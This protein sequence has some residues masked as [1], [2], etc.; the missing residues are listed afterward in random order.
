MGGVYTLFYL[1]ALKIPENVCQKP[2]FLSL[3]NPEIIKEL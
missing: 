2:I 1:E 3:K